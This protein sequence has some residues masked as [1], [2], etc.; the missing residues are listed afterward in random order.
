MPV[1]VTASRPVATSEVARRLVDLASDEPSGVA[2]AI[3][4][5]ESMTVTGMARRVLRARGGRRLVVPLRL[6][7]AGG[8]GFTGG[9]L[10]PT[11]EHVVGTVRFE[12]YLATHRRTAG[13]G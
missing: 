3:A 1:P 6:P 4:G 8:R 5:P 7:G 9:A 10:I 11:C 12:D 2:L 13:E